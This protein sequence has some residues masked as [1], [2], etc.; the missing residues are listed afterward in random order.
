MEGTIS[1]GMPLWMLT[2]YISVPVIA[3]SVF[4]WSLI[5]RK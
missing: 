4:V 5:R 3:A 2:I 1:Q